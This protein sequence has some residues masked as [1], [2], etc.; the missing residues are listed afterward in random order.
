MNV[1]R[2]TNPRFPPHKPV[3]LGYIFREADLRYLIRP[4]ISNQALPANSFSA[5][6]VKCLIAEFFM[7]LTSQ[8]AKSLI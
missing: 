4:K 2:V 1:H 6:R 8:K 5:F 3:L 7:K